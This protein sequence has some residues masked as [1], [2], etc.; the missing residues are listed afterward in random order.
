[1]TSWRSRSYWKAS[2]FPSEPHRRYALPVP[3]FKGAGAVAHFSKLARADSLLSSKSPIAQG[4][5][6]PFRFGSVSHYAR[7]WTTQQRHWR[8]HGT[9]ETRATTTQGSRDSE[10]KQVYHAGMDEFVGLKS[11]SMAWQFT[12]AYRIL[13]RVTSY[14]LYGGKSRLKKHVCATGSIPSRSPGRESRKTMVDNPST[15]SQHTH[16][17]HEKPMDASVPSEA[18]MRRLMVKGCTQS[19]CCNGKRLRPHTN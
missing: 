13:D 19:E 11:A 18:G 17:K 10:E 14:V 12:M 8:R 2:C 16:E 1:M 7:S 5:P 4:T 15:P 3:L 6:N 9:C